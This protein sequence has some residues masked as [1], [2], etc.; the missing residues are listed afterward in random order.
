[1]NFNL[2][3]TVGLLAIIGQ[4]TTGCALQSLSETPEDSKISTDVRGLLEQQADLGPPN[5]I[6]VSTIK[7]VVYLSGSVSTGLG[8]REA[9]E[10]A[11]QA[12]GVARVVNSVAVEQ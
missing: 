7:H 12:P 11:R 9:E 6:H 10:I 2:L 5:F 3:K 4:L 8:E 1:M